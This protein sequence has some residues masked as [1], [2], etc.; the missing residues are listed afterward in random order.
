[1]LKCGQSFCTFDFMINLLLTSRQKKIKCFFTEAIPAAA[2]HATLFKICLV[3]CALLLT[4]HDSCAQRTMIKTHYKNGQ[5][6]SQG[7]MYSY[8][9][10]YDSKKVP[11]KYQFFARLEKKDKAWKY[12][13]PNGQLR[14][15]EHYKLIKNKDPKNLPDG[16]WTYFN[17]QGIK[18]REETYLDGVLTNY[19]KEIY[20]DTKLIGKISL[21]NG[22]ADT[23]FLTPLSFSNNLIINPEFDYFYYKP[24]PVI[25]NGRTKIEAWIPFWVTPGNYTTDYLSNL[26]SIDRLPYQSLFDFPLPDKFTYAGFALYQESESYSEYIQGK[27]ISPLTRGQKYCIKVSI[28]QPNYSG[29]SADRLAFDFSPDPIKVNKSN[30][31]SFSPQVFLSLLPVDDKRFI[32]LCDYFIATG[33]EQFVTI[34]RFTSLDKLEIV[35]RENIPLSQFGIENA[36]YYLL[37]NVELKEIKDTMECYCE[38]N[39]IQINTIKFIPNKDSMIFETDLNKLKQGM[40]VILKNVNFEFNSYRILQS[41]DTV[42]NTL[43]NYLNDNPE[44]RLKI[45]GHTD[46]IGTEEYNLDLSINRAKS[47]YNWLLNKGITSDR[48]EY[49]GLGKTLPLY[50][51]IDEKYRALNRRVEVKI[52]VK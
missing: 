43:L 37:D 52:I 31:T 49:T 50:K 17:E 21:L 12:W 24:V 10:Y 22:I 8:S 45:A 41:A 36:A 11:K 7:L 42:L 27:L 23:T 46:D 30:E 38:K 25:Y 48:L 9:I 28:A 2:L 14:R 26:R 15:I 47:V 33:G 32:T 3:L 1:M 6:E 44:V 16:T 5:L 29:F 4:F 18:Y 19:I 13:Y 34:G 20:C 40:T 51:E 35:H 39:R